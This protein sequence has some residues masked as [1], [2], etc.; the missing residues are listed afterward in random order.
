[1]ADPANPTVRHYRFCTPITGAAHEAYALVGTEDA[2][3]EL[4][5]DTDYCL[6]IKVGNDGGMSATGDFQ[7]QLDIDT[8]GFLNVD[9]ASAGVRITDSGDVDAATGVPER[10]ATSAETY[11]TSLLDEVDGIIPQNVS[12][13]HEWEF[14]FAVNVRSAELSG[15]EALEF[16]LLTGGATFTHNVSILA[17][18]AGAAP[19]GIVEAVIDVASQVDSQKGG[20]GAPSS[21]IDVLTSVVE[22]ANRQAL[23]NAIVDLAVMLD[24]GAA[25]AKTGIIESVVNLRSAVDGQKGA[26]LSATSIIDTLAQVAESA[27]RQALTSSIINLATMVIATAGESKTGI[28]ESIINVQ[29]VVASQKNAQGVNR[30]IADLVSTAIESAGRSGDVDLVID[31]LTRVAASGSRSG[32]LKLIIDIPDQVAGVPQHLGAVESV[33]G[34]RVTANF[35]AGTGAETIHTIALK[36]VFD[37]TFPLDGLV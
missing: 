31:V 26:T 1:M 19:S 35:F 7:L 29:S 15:G 36:G 37:I 10:L 22:L 24:A 18:V 34:V 21:V 27:N 9:A 5:L 16:R 13:G 32:E 12:G 28:A 8:A 4:A 2:S 25:E 30:V 20:E 23:V 33:V 14:Y 17:T 11:Q 6:I 3:F